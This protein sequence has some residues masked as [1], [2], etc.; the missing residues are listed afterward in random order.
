MKLTNAT[1][2]PTCSPAVIAS[3]PPPIQ[4]SA[5]PMTIIA[6]TEARNQRP[7]IARSIS[8]FMRFVTVS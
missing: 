8:S 2:T 3:Q 1:M 6:V 4:T 5:G 7:T